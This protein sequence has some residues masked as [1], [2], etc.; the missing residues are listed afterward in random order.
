LEE[1][2]VGTYDADILWS[3][4]M[5]VLHGI[6]FPFR[7]WIK[8]ACGFFAVSARLGASQKVNIIRLCKSATQEIFSQ[9]STLFFLPQLRIPFNMMTK[10][11]Q[12]CLLQ[13]LQ[14]EILYHAV[15]CKWL[16]CIKLKLLARSKMDICQTRESQFPTTLKRISKPGCI[17]LCWSVSLLTISICKLRWI[18]ILECEVSTKDVLRHVKIEKKYQYHPWF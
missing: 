18:V 13:K 2:N 10:A 4:C 3:N 1:L 9:V 7:Y 15:K 6:L 11:F 12:C 17:C 8:G 16:R 5:Y 14:A